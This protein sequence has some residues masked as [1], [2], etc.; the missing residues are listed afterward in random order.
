M[1]LKASQ[2]AGGADLALHLMNG[3]DNER[4]EVAELRGVV[5][6]DLLGAFAEFEAV[7]LGT[8]ARQPLYSLSI[9]PPES[10]SRERYDQAIAVI[11]ERLGLSAQPRAVIYHE[12]HGREHC[13]VVWS[14]IDIEAMRAI[15]MSHDHR[16]LMDVACA[17]CHEFGFAMPEGLKRWEARQSYDKA[18]LE[19]TLA[20]KAQAEITGLS[21]EQRRAEIT[22]AYERAD[23]PDALGHALEEAG[24]ILARGDR[25]SLVVIDRF[26][27]VHSL[28]RYIKGPSAK[29]K[30]ARLARVDLDGLPVVEQAREMAAQ[31]AQARRDLE[32]E[33]AARR[34]QEIDQALGQW[35]DKQRDKLRALKEQRALSVR[36]ARQAL[37]TRQQQERLALHAAQKSEAR[38]LLFRVRRAV[39][40]LIEKTPALRSVLGPLQ[41]AGLDPALRHVCERAALA[42]RH[43]FEEVDVARKERL[44]ERLAVRERQ[45]FIRALKKQE[46]T[47]RA[48]LRENGLK[49]EIEIAEP[50][51][52]AARDWGFW[53]DR[54]FAPGEVAEE[55]NAKT[56]LGGPDGSG[57]NDGDQRERSWKQRAEEKQEKQR[58]HK[59]KKGKG[60]GSGLD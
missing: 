22:A 7:A 10:M 2:R 14:R 30:R 42:E 18:A 49:P 45:S 44:A 26:G 43:R 9:S 25:R 12:K 29:E 59:R 60:Y 38:G 58:S 31:R 1:I 13:H 37:L 20:E 15:P 11:E 32:R 21:A 16:R 8:K 50:F 51:Y 53:R 5:A 34:R 56:A 17:L 57:A 36:Q 40:Q 52:Q 39:V 47:L 23:S 55:F 3:F 28:S 19:P 46:R 41:G 24:Y 33:Q 4:I 35:A 48:Q 54:K 6:D 27:D